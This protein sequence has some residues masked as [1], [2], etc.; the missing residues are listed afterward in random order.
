MVTGTGEVKNTEITFRSV[1]SMGG[2]QV[3]GLNLHQEQSVAVK[4]QLRDACIAHSFLLIRD[5]DITLE[6]QFRFGRIF[7]DVLESDSSHQQGSFVT[8]SGEIWL[9]FDHWLTSKS[10]Q[11]VHFTMLYGMKVV[12]V[13]GETVFANGRRAYQLL[14]ALLKDRI[15]SLQALHC[16]DY[17]Y[18]PGKKLAM[19][20]REAEIDQDQ[21]RA[22]YP[23]VFKHSDTGEKILYV[24]PRN[25]DRILDLAPE[26]SEALLEELWSHLTSQGNVYQHR[27]AIGD[28]LIWDNHVLLHGRTDFDSKHQRR[29]RRMCII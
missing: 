18:V 3:F 20:I 21:P 26:A 1:S 22:V 9:H 4:R 23:V 24:S 19:R 8:S 27:W 6:E 28:L 17:S 5:Q 16:Y 29:L 15:E 13:G 7:G 25:T 12:P 11:P 14:P 10:P 2:A